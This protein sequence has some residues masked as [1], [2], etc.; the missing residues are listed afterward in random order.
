[1]NI[2]SLLLTSSLVF[3]QEPTPQMDEVENESGEELPPLVKN[4]EL[5]EYVQA[6]YPPEAKA[7]G[8][9]GTVL[10]LIEIDEAGDVS[11]IEVLRSAG[12]DFDAA[13]TE[14]AWEFVF[15]PAEDASGPVPV[16]IEFEYGFVLDASSVEGAIE[17]ETE[18]L[19]LPIN[20]DG[21][22]KEM[23][24]KRL[25]KDVSVRAELEDGTN[26]ETTT[27]E[28]GYYAFRGLPKGLVKLEAVFPDFNGEIKSVAVTDTELTSVQ[29]WLKNKNYRDDE[30]VGVYRKPSADI[31]KRSLSVEE[32]RRIPGTFGD[33]IRVIQNLPGAA[34]SPF[35]TGLLIIRGANPEDSGVYVDGIRI[36]LIYHLGGIVSVLN[37]DLIETV[38]YLPG[39][40]GVQYGRTLGGVV[41]VKTKTTFPEQNK[42]SWSTDVLDSG[43]LLQVKAGDYGVAVAA[44]RS[45]ID[46][47]IPAFTQNTGFVIK[48]RWFDYQLKVTRLNKSKAP[49][50]FFLF[51]FQDILRVSTP[52]DVPQGTD[53]DT[54]GDFDTDYATH[55][56]YF[57]WEP[58][59]S[60]TWRLR[61]TPSFGIDTNSISLGD[62]L[63]LNQANP[64][65]E[66]R[67]E[68]IW[69]LKEK[70]NVTAGMD[71][72]GGQY[73]FDAR[74][75]FSIDNASNY[76]PL[77]ERDSTAF[78]GKGYV[79]APDLYVKAEFRPLKDPDRWLLS[80][81][82]RWSVIDLRD[83]ISDTKLLQ[84]W[85]W[86][87]R[88]LS[89]FQVFEGGFL[90]SGI[91]IYTQPPQPFEVWRPEGDTQ[92]EFERAYSSEIG[93]EQYFTDALRADV[94]FFGKYL[95]NLIVNNPAA[96]NSGDLFYVNEGIGRVY[97]M[98]MIIRQAPVNRFFG[99]ISY[100]LSRSERN[101][102]PD[103]NDLL[104]EDDVPN[105]PSTGG[106][107][108]F[109]LDQTHILVAV[110]GYRLPYDFN[111][112][113]KIQ[114]V[115][116]NP[117]TPYAG[118]VYDIDQDLY[119]AFP[120][121]EYNSE[122]LPPFVSLDLRFDKLFS[123]QKWQLETYA[124]FLNVYR[125]ENPEF[126]SYNYDYTESRYIRGLP[127]IPSL[128]FNAM[129]SF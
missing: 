9:E 30:L 64:Y 87:P 115:T 5:Q 21:V 66:V 38:D 117:F 23:G 19:E 82:I 46:L 1:M 128:G 51:G 15:S 53:Q 45:Y 32:I 24:T 78:E 112:S 129:V 28:E 122:R 98:E 124:D 59:L 49:L 36:P 92:L 34:R 76:D 17:D 110:A 37:A 44:R 90:K 93:W 113:S 61:L 22:V 116:G 81:G 48:P 56:A 74:F 91:G 26:I 118:G 95:D 27:S 121:S 47:F 125:G 71:F 105:S 62:G 50:S 120:S 8:R 65:L 14:A 89:R 63:R 68:S 43:G 33:P 104:D 85:G 73:R 52:D 60:D 55:R 96:T 127:F 54:Q 25:L 13:A 10:L 11:Y 86:D 107:Y 7:E 69:D 94:T 16:A 126:T 83:V 40:Y 77:Q 12:A 108:L 111:I 97:G 39:S 80:P 42:F 72:I 18:E 84:A 123:F 109:D 3:S 67:A 4:P 100:T 101:N 106:W 99:W 119:F 75:P 88:L 57:M 6:P 20:L 35:G 2:F 103:R 114:Y 29:L 41:D 79:W 102:Y 31:T 58:R 70:H